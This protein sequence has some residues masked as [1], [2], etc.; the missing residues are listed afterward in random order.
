[1]N[2]RQSSLISKT[3]TREITVE[4]VAGARNERLREYK[5]FFAVRVKKKA[6]GNY[7]NTR[8]RELIALHF[9]VPVTAVRIS[10]GH[11]SRRKILSV[12]MR[13]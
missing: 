11:T 6:S 8:V 7:A 12:T 1:M 3:H 4:V 9:G 13:I 2:R 5:D 10:R